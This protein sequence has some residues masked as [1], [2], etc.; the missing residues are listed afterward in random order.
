[1][2]NAGSSAARSPSSA[3][4]ARARLDEPPGKAAGGKAALLAGLARSGRYFSVAMPNGST[5]HLLGVFPCSSRCEEEAHGLVGALAPSHVYVDLAPEWVAALQEEVDAGRVGGWAI[6]DATPPFRLYPGAGVL[7]SVL[8]RNNIADNDMLGLMGA[9]WYGP[10]K[11]GLAAA[12]K[13]QQAAAAAAGA[14]ASGT[15]AAVAAGGGPQSSG[16]K[17][18]AFPFSM[19]YNNGETLERPSAFTCLMVGN[20]SFASDAVH[21]LAGANA[22]IMAGEPAQAETTVQLPPAG[23]F[24]RQQ[25]RQAGR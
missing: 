25:V 2:G 11:A 1:M 5:V 15:G 14:A 10:Y 9:E 13:Q 22:A 20:S 21:A 23:Y 24:T 18:L 3:L 4:G 19:H 17:V 7:G 8:I 6:P 12:R 16:P